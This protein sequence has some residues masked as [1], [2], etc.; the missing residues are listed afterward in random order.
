MINKSAFSNIQKCGVG[1]VW[2]PQTVISIRGHKIQSW[3]EKNWQLNG[4]FFTISQ[5]RT[6]M[7]EHTQVEVSQQ[8]HNSS[9]NHCSECNSNL[10]VKIF[11]C[12]FYHLKHNG[13]YTGGLVRVGMNM[14]QQDSEQIFFVLSLRM[15]KTSCLT[16]IPSST[17]DKQNWYI[18]LSTVYIAWRRTKLDEYEGTL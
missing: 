7:H 14:G 12:T 16:N 11:L 3:L 9:T 4:R 6:H 5:A 1:K 15:E 2:K 18:T 17:F 10:R 8:E 13:S